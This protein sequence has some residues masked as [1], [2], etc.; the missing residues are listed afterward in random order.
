MSQTLHRESRILIPVR[1]RVISQEQL[2]SL[3]LALGSLMDKGVRLQNSR[4]RMSPKGSF[5]FDD[6]AVDVD[7]SGE[8]SVG[9]AITAC[10]LSAATPLHDNPAIRNAVCRL[11]ESHV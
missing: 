6:F 8:E 4:V 3:R 1:E 7:E 9:R 5:L 2:D 11:V 10:G